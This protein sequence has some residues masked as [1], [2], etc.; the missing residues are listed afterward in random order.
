MELSNDFGSIVRPRNKTT[1]GQNVNRESVVMG[2]HH[3]HATR[4]SR[5]LIGNA[6]SCQAL[7]SK[8]ASGAWST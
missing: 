8:R 2:Y 7:E 3:D 4:V 5:S 6:R 1:I